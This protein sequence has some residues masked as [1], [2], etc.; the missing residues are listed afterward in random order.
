M[1]RIRS[2]RAGLAALAATVLLA[3]PAHSATE[4]SGGAPGSWLMG[5]NGARTL[6]LGGA[7]V[8]CADDA[9]GAL[10]NPAGLQYMDQNQLMFE[11]VRLFEDT[12]VNSFGFA[13]PGN[14]LPSFGLSMVSLRSGEFE[15]TNEM[16]DNLGT[17]QET[18]TAYL[19]TVAKSVSKRMALG[20]NL[21]LVQ[22]G[23]EDA[24]AGGYGFDVGA[25]VEVARG[26]KVAAAA[27]NLGGPSITLRNTAE[28]FEP[29]YRGGVSMEMFGG[30]GL[31]STQVDVGGGSSARFHAGSEY[32]IQP[33]MALRVGFDEDRATGGFSYKFAPQYQIDYGAADHPLGMS[34]RVALS[35]RFGGFFASSKAE[36]QVFSPTGERAT[37]QIQLNA[38]TKSTADQWTLDIVDKAD[39]VVRKF[40][41]PGL[42]PPH[43][44]WDGKDETGLPAADG[45]YSYRLVVKDRAGRV[46]ESANRKVEIS[47][48]GPQ[49]SV[50]VVPN[51]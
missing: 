25:I 12:S 27:A 33:G 7:F 50:P 34:H 14:W 17:F 24:S 5:Y 45:F 44:Q 22:Q 51:P 10:W 4:D 42:P 29:Q 11:N 46:L 20:A 13:V 2:A 39:R 47:T 23:V 40:S 43:V 8:A 35:Y 36:P 16:N 19:F 37:T 30:R 49:V 28:E 3:V 18:E 38:R 1:N 41:G 9:L 6:G 31:I 15:R 21:K 48:G 26:L 32:W